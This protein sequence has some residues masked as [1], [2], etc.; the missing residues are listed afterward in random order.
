MTGYLKKYNKIKKKFRK[1]I[2]EIQEMG[3]YLS[4]IEKYFCNIFVMI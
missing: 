1:R 4:L 3:V 2:D